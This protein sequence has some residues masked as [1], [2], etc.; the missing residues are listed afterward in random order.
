MD[1]NDSFF[2][3]SR[4][5]HFSGDNLCLLAVEQPTTSLGSPWVCVDDVET[6]NGWY[7]AKRCGNI[8]D[9]EKGQKL[10]RTTTGI[11]VQDSLSREIAGIEA[12]YAATSC[13][14]VLWSGTAGLASAM[15]RAGLLSQCT[16]THRSNIS[17]HIGG[18]SPSDGNPV[19]P[20]HDPAND[21][22]TLTPF[23]SQ[24][25]AESRR[26]AMVFRV[27]LTRVSGQ[28]TSRNCTLIPSAELFSRLP[29]SQPCPPRFP[30]PEIVFLI[31]SCLVSSRPVLGGRQETY[32][33]TPYNRVINA[34]MADPMGV[35][36]SLIVIAGWAVKITHQLDQMIQRYHDVHAVKAFRSNF[37]SARR[38]L[39]D[40]S[41][42]DCAGWIDGIYPWQSE[43]GRGCVT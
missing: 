23:H 5:L 31:N 2:L 28:S 35:M 15:C 25:P 8:R 33:T 1:E 26:H 16:D 29:P 34:K 20:E 43:P 17:F 3:L 11:F 27:A 37:D 30:S 38:I 13:S 36:A 4:P 19:A 21:P 41:E 22:I 14:H 9:D 40:L 10:L 39:D 6:D 42:E 32:Q 12:N 7:L 18:K 24:S